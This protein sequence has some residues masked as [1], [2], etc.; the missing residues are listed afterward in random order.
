[1]HGTEQR[2]SAYALTAEDRA[3]WDAHRFVGP[4]TAWTP[5]ETAAL[6]PR[7]L[8]AFRRPS[9]AYGFSTIKNRH[10]DCLAIHQAGTHPAILERIAQLLGPDLLLWRSRLFHKP[11][12]ADEIL[13]HQGRD[14]PGLHADVPSIEPA[15]AVTCWLALTET[16]RANG[17]MKL[18]PG[19]HHA[20]HDLEPVEGHG[21]FGRGLK[22][23]GFDDVEPTHFELQPGQ[24]FLFSESVVHGSDANRSDADRTGV[25]F[26]YTPTS[27]RVYRD[28]AIDGAGM[29]TKGWHAVLVRGEDTHG[30]NKLGPPPQVDAPPMSV[31]RRALSPLRRR[32]YQRVHG[33]P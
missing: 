1:V 23:K 30:H 13:Y 3:S 4:F 12:G 22:L 18:V 26:R 25:V 28:M 7:M 29:P 19:S 8:A 15:V 20:W 6:R 9:T 14:W 11:P 27:T 32:W 2:N 33:M 21:L 31:F 24:F 17:C 16:T 5:D 10:L